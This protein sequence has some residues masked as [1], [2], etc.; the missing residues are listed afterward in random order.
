MSAEPERFADLFLKPSVEAMYALSPREFER[1]VAYVLRRAGHN[2][3]EV[4]PHWLKGVDLEMRRPGSTRIIGGVE[5][6][7]YQPDGLVVSQVVS[8]LLSAASVS[9]PAAKAYVVTTGD[10]H[11][12][13]HKIAEAG[14]K[15]AHLM[16][17]A[18]L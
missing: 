9:G 2:V 8:H 14:A 3:Q 16:N 6:K 4:G 5:C 12:N 18:Q 1:F 15:K 17:G 13:A 10:F 11:P 7:R